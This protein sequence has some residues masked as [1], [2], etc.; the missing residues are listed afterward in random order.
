M[1]QLNTACDCRQK[2][3]TTWIQEGGLNRQTYIPD[4]SWVENFNVWFKRI[5]LF[6]QSVQSCCKKPPDLCID[7]LFVSLICINKIYSLTKSLYRES[8]TWTCWFLYRLLVSWA[9]HSQCPSWWFR[10]ETIGRF[11]LWRRV[12]LLS[13]P[14]KRQVLAAC[15]QVLKSPTWKS[16]RLFTISAKIVPIDQMSIGQEYLGEPK[17]T[18]GALDRDF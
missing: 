17:S 13:H 5:N 12:G 3:P 18:S 8:K 6:P 14:V 16:G 2:A 10:P 15:L 7:K 4:C 9:Q 1:T 11:S